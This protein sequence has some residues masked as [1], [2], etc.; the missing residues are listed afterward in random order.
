MPFSNRV[1]LGARDVLVYKGMEIDRAILDALIDG[2]KRLL[3]AFVRGERG[4]VRAVP[5]SEEQV[6]WMAES[7]ILKEKEV[8]L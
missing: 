3:W 2:D 8:E 5:Y 4:D 7:D 1:E 6:I